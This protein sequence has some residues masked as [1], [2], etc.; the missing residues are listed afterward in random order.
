VTRIRLTCRNEN[1]RNN[2]HCVIYQLFRPIYNLYDLPIAWE[3]LRKDYDKNMPCT[4]CRVQREPSFVMDHFASAKVIEMTN[5]NKGALSLGTA[6]NTLNMEHLTVIVFGKHT[7]SDRLKNMS[8]KRCRNNT[9][10]VLV[11]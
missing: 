8:Q 5:V 4:A 11:R 3:N 2:G 7:L 10:Y 6:N 9:K 1:C